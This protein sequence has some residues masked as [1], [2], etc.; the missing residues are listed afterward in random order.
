LFAGADLRVC[1][2]AIGETPALF[3]TLFGDKPGKAILA[4]VDRICLHDAVLNVAMVWKDIW[5][6]F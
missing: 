3:K 4:E 6:K 2:F 1:P 5:G